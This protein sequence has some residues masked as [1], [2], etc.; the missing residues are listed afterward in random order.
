MG[1]RKRIRE[2]K[3]GR[4]RGGRN[5]S[6]KKKKKIERGGGEGGKQPLKGKKRSPFHL[7]GEIDPKKGLGKTK[8]RRKKKK[9]L[10][11]KKS[12]IG[13]LE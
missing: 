13:K 8:K 5:P 3:G 7:Q 6:G 10:E 11:R 2:S 12:R 4:K 1:V 9:S